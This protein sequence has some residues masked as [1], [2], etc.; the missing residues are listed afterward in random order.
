M[1]SKISDPDLIEVKSPENKKKP[2]KVMLYLLPY[3]S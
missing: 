1:P 3:G 2:R